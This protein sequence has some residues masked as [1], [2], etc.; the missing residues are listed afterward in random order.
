MRPGVDVAG[1]RARK[2]LDPASSTPV[3]HGTPISFRMATEEELQGSTSVPSNQ[4]DDSTYGVRS[5]QDTI[6]DGTSLY[7]NKKEES[8]TQDDDEISQSG[9]RYPTL[10]PKPKHQTR[11]SSRENVGPSHPA[12]GDSSPSHPIQEGP[13]P[14]SMSH[15]LASLSLDS[16][17]PLSSLPSSPKSTSNRSFRP[18]DED[19]IDDGGSQAIASSED[20]D[21][22]PHSEIQDSSPQLI[23]PSI[24]LPSRRPF[25]DRGRRMG[26]LKVLIAGDSG[27]QS[28]IQSVTKRNDSGNLFDQGVGKSSLIK[29]IV[30]TCEDI[31][32]V[33]PLSSNSPSIELLPG[34]K[35]SKQDS[36]S[37]RSTQH[38]TEVFASTKP[39]PTWWSDI[40]DTKVLRRRKSLGDTVLERNLCFVDTPGY[41]NGIS[42]METIQSVLQYIEVQLSKPFSALTASEG[43][44][45]GLLSGGGGTQVDVVFYLIARGTQVSLSEVNGC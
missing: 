13:S 10:R 12:T 34:Q 26:R 35:S 23:M 6:Y 30:Q 40:E 15:S 22:E 24:K 27:M 31:V 38:I 20:D 21:V 39:Y 19:S 25:T 5:L 45:A 16:Q 11:D 4:V 9:R 33:D 7:K 36:R 32:H 41:N 18:S 17:A 1:G 8:D 29:S 3:G 37:N 2:E 14:P 28:N 44:I 42:K 43:D